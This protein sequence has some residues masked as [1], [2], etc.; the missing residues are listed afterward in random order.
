MIDRPRHTSSAVAAAV[1]VCV[2]E[3]RPPFARL[4]NFAP[5]S[6]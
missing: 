2:L 5:K 6:N 1:C 3:T 4:K